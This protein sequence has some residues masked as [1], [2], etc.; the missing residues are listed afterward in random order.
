MYN[1]IIQEVTTAKFS[2]SRPTL[3]N[4]HKL[5]SQPATVPSPKNDIT[6]VTIIIGNCFHGCCSKYVG[7]F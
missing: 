2:V 5:G 6:L 3:L 1:N 4:F 7:N